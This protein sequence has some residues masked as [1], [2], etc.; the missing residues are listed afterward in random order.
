MSDAIANLVEQSFPA[1]VR[2]AEKSNL[3][4]WAE[5]S[6]FAMQA[7]SKNNKLMQCEKG[8]IRDAIINVAAVGLTLNPAFGYAYLVP[9]ARNAG[10]KDDPNW[11]QECHLRVSFKGLIKVATDS[12]TIEWVAADVVKKN[13]SFKFNGKWAL[14][15]HEMDPFSE[16][17]GASVGVYCVA[18]MHD[19]QYICETAPWSE[20]LKAKNAAK[21]QSVWKDW[22]DEMAKKFII[23]RASKQWPKTDQTQRMEETVSIINAYEGSEDSEEL[24]K[25]EEVAAYL[26]E[27][28]AEDDAE[29]VLEAYDELTDEEKQRLW[30]AKT[31]G[32][33]LTQDEKKYIKEKG[34][35][36]YK[37]KETTA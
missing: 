37:A 18:R 35:E 19:G 31:K 17:R 12:G 11:I 3:V 24:Q 9:E 2:I 33:W 4:R 6:Q 30:T 1:F 10:T 16:D 29:S 26:I 22:E 21:T 34:F 32:G 5:E 23:K 27:H 7:I 14:P 28:I 36:A 8:T 20:V 15:V 25:L 13:D